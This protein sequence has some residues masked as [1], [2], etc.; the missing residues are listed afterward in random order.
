MNFIRRHYIYEIWFIFWK[1]NKEV[2]KIHGSLSSFTFV[3]CEVPSESESVWFLI[4]RRMRVHVEAL[5]QSMSWIFLFTFKKEKKQICVRRFISDI[6]EVLF[7]S[8]QIHPTI[9]PLGCFIVPLHLLFLLPFLLL[10]QWLKVPCLM[11]WM[12]V[13]VW[14]VLCTHSF[15]CLCG[16]WMF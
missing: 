12:G 2:K 11:K 6:W 3:L 14:P 8:F 1:N 13:T 7:F 9:F 10:L 15:S 16:L 4:K 5:I